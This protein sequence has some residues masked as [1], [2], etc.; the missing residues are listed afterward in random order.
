[1]IICRLIPAGTD[2]NAA[3]NEIAAELQADGCKGYVIPGGGSNPLG[4]LGYVACAEEL[5]SQA[6]EQGLRIDYIVCASGSAGTHA[7]TLVGLEG[8]NR[9]VPLT[10]INV[11]R[12]R[13]E[14]EKNVH[15]LAVATAAPLGIMQPA[16]EKVIALDERVGPGYS[17]PTAEMVDAVRILASLE[18]VLLDPVSIP[19]RQLLASS[20]SYAEEPSK[21]RKTWC[22]CIPAGLRR[23]MRTKRQSSANENR[24]RDRR[25]GAC[26]H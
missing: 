26:P 13:V 17:L 21:M 2:L 18:G 7:G 6:F 14:Q 24:W 16:R 10:G 23:S 5:M 3:M 12:K 25:N 20:I 9:C 22:F 8:A 11:R 19:V 4:A 1:M 15:A